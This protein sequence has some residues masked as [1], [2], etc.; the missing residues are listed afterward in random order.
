MPRPDHRVRRHG[1]GCDNFNGAANGKRDK[2]YVRAKRALAEVLIGKVEKIVP[3]LS[4]SIV[5]S[6][7]ATPFTFERYT[8]ATGGAWYDGVYPAGRPHKG[9]KAKTP[10]KGLYLTGT[11]AFAGGGMPPAIVDGVQ[12]ARCVLA[13]R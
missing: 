9:L 13:N 5:V 1:Q 10:I 6:E 8:G 7:M 3:G 4:G 12:A 11:K 2:E